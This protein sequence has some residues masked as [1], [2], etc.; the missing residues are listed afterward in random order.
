VTISRQSDEPCD[1]AYAAEAR[2]HTAQF[3][4]IYVATDLCEIHSAMAHNDVVHQRAPIR[5]EVF[6]D[7][8]SKFEAPTAEERPLIYSRNVPIEKW[9]ASYV[10][11]QN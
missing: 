4:L 3:I 7:H 2:R 9:L 5:P 6:Q 11:K 10:T 1:P 8:A